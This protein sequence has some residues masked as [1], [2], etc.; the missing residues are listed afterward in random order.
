[1]IRNLLRKFKNI[2]YFP[3]NKYK[4]YQIK[5]LPEITNESI[6]S[7]KWLSITEKKYGGFVKGV[8]VHQ[9]SSEDDRG[10]EQAQKEGMQ[11]G[12]RMLFHG[13][14]SSYSKHLECF[15]NNVENNYTLVEVGILKGTG[16][17]LWSDLF[18][19]SRLIG[20]DIDLENFK[21]NEE[22]LIS[23]G[24]FKKTK[25]ELYL[26]DQLNPDDGLI[27]DILLD[28]KIDIA[29]DDGLHSKD[30]VIKTAETILPY[31]SEKSVY[32]IEDFKFTKDCIE[33]IAER[34][35]FKIDYQGLLSIL[36]K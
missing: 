30:S 2:L 34:Y 17:A 6:G 8:P 3:I 33:P 1:M 26:F 18:P 9:I 24:A 27:S 29:I 4:L 22:Y 7:V 11:G 20:L 31:M 21:K 32:F 19:E 36:Y 16:L 13:Y 5:K 15:L 25:P 23:K 12:D 35:N 10:I 14:A 28:T